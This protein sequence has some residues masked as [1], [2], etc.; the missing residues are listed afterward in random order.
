MRLDACVRERG[1][2]CGRCRPHAGARAMRMRRVM[3]HGHANANAPARDDRAR[4]CGLLRHAHDRARPHRRLRT[5]TSTLVPARPPRLTLRISSRA[6]TF[7]AAVVSSSRAKGTP[8]STSAPSSMSPLMP[9]KHSKYPIRME[10]KLYAMRRAA[11]APQPAAPRS[12]TR[13]ENPCNRASRIGSPPC[14]APPRSCPSSPSVSA[15]GNSA[16]AISTRASSP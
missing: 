12:M 13:N 10:M 3:R 5:I 8:A 15:R 4:E 16:R 6:P 9:E 11:S 1:R 2:A 14:A 7:S